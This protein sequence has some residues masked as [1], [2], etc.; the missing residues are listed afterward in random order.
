MRP[1]VTSDPLTIL[2]EHNR[3]ATHKVLGLCR[4]SRPRSNFTG[5]ST[6]GRD[7]C[8]TR[9]GTSCRTCGRGPTTPPRA[10]TQTVAGRVRRTGTR[11]D[12]I[13]RLLDEATDDL[14][15]LIDES[16]GRLHEHVR[17][18]FRE[19]GPEFTYTRGVVLTHVLVHGTHHRAQCL[20]MLRRLDVPGVSDRL[21][22][23]DV[24]EWQHETECKS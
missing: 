5:G 4:A 12:E 10:Q 11:R 15:Q 8:T 14:R 19:D 16:R 21:P 17:V 18:T 20:N 7:R 23:I 13:G 2:L 6:S 3:W 9:C 24:N 22:D 1:P